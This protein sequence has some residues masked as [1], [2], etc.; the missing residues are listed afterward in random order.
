MKKFTLKTQNILFASIITIFITII[1]STINY[2]MNMN[3]TF[4]RLSIICEQTVKAW[5]K[6]MP[7]TDVEKIINHDENQ[8]KIAIA[9]FD[10]LAEYQ[11]Q[12]AQGYLFGVELVDGTGTS[13]ISGPS[14]LMHDFDKSNLH[15]GD[16][17]TQP[18]V[19]ANAIKDMKQTNK[20]TTSS[21]YTDDYGKWLTVLKPLFNAEGEMFAYYG[22]DFDAQPYLDAEAKKLKMTICIAIILLIIVCLI[23]YFFMTKLFQPL[24]AMKVSMRKMAVGDYTTQ[25]KEGPNEIGQISTQFNSMSSAI[26]SMLESIQ[27]T[28]DTSSKQAKKLAI[29][30]NHSLIQSEE[31]NQL[32]TKLAIHLQEQKTHTA[33]LQSFTNDQLTSSLNLITDKISTVTALNKY[34][35]QKT[36]AGITAFELLQ[37]QLIQLK[38]APIQN[39]ALSL[40]ESSKLVTIIGEM[41]REIHLQNVDISNGIQEIALSIN[42]ISK[43]QK[44]LTTL[45]SNL[46]NTSNSDIE[47]ITKKLKNQLESFEKIVVSTKNMNDIISELEVLIFSFKN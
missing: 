13:V 31:L 42:D 37:H 35:N 39:R 2:F 9:Y 3:D 18:Q 17:Y 46:D 34:S 12:V 1:L 24:S 27:E 40:N 4:H 41:F 25:L 36:T 5:S 15:I 21:V 11:P 30:A 7:V 16:I 47:Q 22:I 14:F 29:D 26:A 19:I 32:F 20:L 8:Q 33:E 28:S 23:Q 45:H 10:K 6:D 43:Q 38:N 44:N